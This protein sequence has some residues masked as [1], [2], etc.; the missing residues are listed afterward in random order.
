[1][2]LRASPRFVDAAEGGVL[3]V[4]HQRPAVHHEQPHV[5][6]RRGRQVF[7]GDAV[8]VA[9]HG[10]DHLVEVGPLLGADEEHVLAAGALQRLDHDLVVL[11]VDESLDL[12][13]IAAD[14]RLRPHLFGEVLEV[15]FV[16]R[17]GQVLR[18]VE[19]HHAAAGHELAEQDAG[20]LGPGA[21]GRVGRR[22]VAQQ[23]HVELV[24]AD[25]LRLVV[26]RLQLSRNF[27]SDL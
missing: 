21:L 9:H 13:D 27:S 15:G 14:A 26:L 1:M 23:Q 16:E 10:V 8:A 22:I 5:A 12:V 20:R 19:H 24:E 17:V 25:R 18:V 11:L 2:L 4:V 3:A 6:F 7:L